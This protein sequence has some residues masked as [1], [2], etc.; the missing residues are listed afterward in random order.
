[1]STVTTL[2]PVE[3]LAIAAAVFGRY[4]ESAPVLRS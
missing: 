2:E 3:I 1:M 4:L